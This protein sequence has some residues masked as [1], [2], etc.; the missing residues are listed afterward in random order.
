M[1]L[2]DYVHGWW[3]WSSLLLFFLN[4]H[5]ICVSFLNR[6]NLA[7]I[8]NMYLFCIIRR[9]AV[10]SIYTNS[11]NYI[12]NPS[13]TICAHKLPLKQRYTRL[14]ICELNNN[15]NDWP[16]RLCTHSFGMNISTEFLRKTWNYTFTFDD[17]SFQIFSWFGI[18]FYCYKLIKDLEHLK[19]LY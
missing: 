16:L 19:L 5:L 9:M 13:S 6:E 18:S 1:L 7:R 3:R 14:T 4:S 15:Y 11:N 8:C 2:K 10:T 17:L 12:C